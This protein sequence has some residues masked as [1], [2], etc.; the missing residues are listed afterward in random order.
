MVQIHLQG[1]LH[2]V[3][4]SDLSWAIHKEKSLR[5]EPFN[6]NIEARREFPY[7]TLYNFEAAAEYLLKKTV[8]SLS[9]SSG[10]YWFC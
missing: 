1:R 6:S 2:N 7:K 8:P 5:S 10:F 3:I 4:N 9:I